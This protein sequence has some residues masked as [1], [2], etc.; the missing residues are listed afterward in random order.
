M[1]KRQCTLTSLVEVLQQNPMG[2]H[3]SGHGLLNN[4]K[5]IGADLALYYEGK[6]DLLLLETETGDSQLVCREELKEMI[7]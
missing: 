1:V 7:R 6:G 2:I 3:F 5:S 4:V